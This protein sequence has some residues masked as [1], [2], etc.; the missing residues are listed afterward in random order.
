M[1]DNRMKITWEVPVSLDGELLRTFLRKHKQMSRKALAEIKLRGGG[2]FVNGKESDVRTILRGKDH[3]LVLFP[4]EQASEALEPLE[5]P[6]TIV[7]EDDHMLVIDKPAGLPTVPSSREP[8]LSLAHGVIHYYQQQH[9]PATFHGVTRLDR[10]TS[11]L[12]LVAK[13]RYAH[14]QFVK[15]G[16]KREY[17]VLLEGSLPRNEGTVKYPIGRKGSS[18][19]EREVRED[20][21]HAVTHFE[22]L[23]K[24]KR[25]TKVK[26]RLE[27]GRT[28]QIRV[29]F[30]HLGFPLAGDTL[31]GGHTHKISRQ[32]LHSACLSFTHPFTG[33]HHR[34][35]S[36]VPHDMEQAWMEEG[37][38]NK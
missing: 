31:Y 25:L 17:E 18:I 23:E 14:D 35:E 10:N 6:L 1:I 9:I 37:N 16:L 4:P 5:I 22:V 36:K 3:V 30:S 27:T 38:I 21:Q 7:A 29:H 20:G 12:L 24:N 11:G 26:V 13:H 28:H 32:A 8:G 2:L 15:A 19:I 34:Y 33:E